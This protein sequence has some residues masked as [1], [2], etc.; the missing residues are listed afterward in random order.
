MIG[1]REAAERLGLRPLGRIVSSAVVGVA[2]DRFSI[3]PVGAIRKAVDRA[4]I[5][6][7]DLAVVELN[8]A[9]SA[10]VLCCLRD[11]PEIDHHRVNPNGGAIAYG[12]PLGASAP[13][14]ML[15]LCLNLRHAGGGIGVAAC[16]IGVGQGIAVVIE[17][18]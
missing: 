18:G 2:P 13:R 15:D 11:L 5:R 8:E 3:A 14:T 17:A 12:H 6:L 1:S 10:Q 7:E 16:C 9:F 4:D